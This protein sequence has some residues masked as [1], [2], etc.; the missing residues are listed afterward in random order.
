MIKT[1]NYVLETQNIGILDDIIKGKY[2]EERKEIEKIIK[3]CKN[4]K[5]LI[6]EHNG[7]YLLDKTLREHP[8][9]GINAINVAPEFGVVET[10]AILSYLSENNLEEL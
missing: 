7:D 3:Y 4:E 10:R 2:D 9:I 6:K 1:G 8:I 5:F